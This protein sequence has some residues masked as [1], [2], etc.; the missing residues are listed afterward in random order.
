MG[1]ALE[2][3]VRTKALPAV[4]SLTATCTPSV[5][6]ADGS[7][8]GGNQMLSDLSDSRTPKAAYMLQTQP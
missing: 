4:P 2:Q 6:A 3:T 7:E 5:Q 8:A 1:S